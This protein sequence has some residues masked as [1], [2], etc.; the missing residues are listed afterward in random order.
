M[1]VEEM[2]TPA[3][4]VS[5]DALAQAR[6]RRADL[7]KVLVEL[8]AALASPASG[9]IEEWSLRVHEGLVELGAAFERHIAVTEGPQGL[10]DE[11]RGFA[12]RLANGVDLLGREHRELRRAI[13]EALDAVQRIRTTRD[14]PPANGRESVLDVLEQLMR[15]RQRGADLVYEAYA[16][17]IGGGD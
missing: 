5:A 2:P 1:T 3:P 10:F 17:D 7:H 12:P 13:G 15:H 14:E 16:V 9:R 11:I 6:L 4:T 8:E